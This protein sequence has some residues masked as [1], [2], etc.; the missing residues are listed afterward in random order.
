MNKKFLSFAVLLSIF[1]LPFAASAADVTVQSIVDGAVT[2][3]FYIGGGVVAALWIVAGILFLIAN[4][5]PAKLG[6]AK[7]ALFGAIAGTA[8]IIVARSAIY[9]VGHA[10]N[11]V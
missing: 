6:T 8:V 5:D 4:G 2:T 9:L 3:V 1:A 10:I 11:A 7:K